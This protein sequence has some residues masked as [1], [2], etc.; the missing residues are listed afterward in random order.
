MNTAFNTQIELS[1]LKAFAEDKIN[2]LKK[3]YIAL[4]RIKNMG[5]KNALYQQSLPFPRMLSKG[6]Q[7][8]KI[9]KE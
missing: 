9:S 3:L 2:M 6:F 8:R 7:I 1:N 5:K 4:A